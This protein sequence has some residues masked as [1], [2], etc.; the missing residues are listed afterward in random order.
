MNPKDNWQIDLRDS[1]VAANIRHTREVIAN[2]QQ[3]TG[4]LLA[5]IDE[6][7]LEVRKLS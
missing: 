4:K 3:K 1:L 5:E 6:L 2:I 7:L